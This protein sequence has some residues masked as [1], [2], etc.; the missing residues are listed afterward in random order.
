MGAKRKRSGGVHQRLAADESNASLPQSSRLGN[1]LLDEW[2]WGKASAQQVQHTAQLAVQDMKD[3]GCANPPAD[4]VFLASLGSGGTHANN[5]HRDLLKK[6]SQDS[7]M[8]QPTIT[9]LPLKGGSVPQSFF[10]PHEVF[11]CLYHEHP[12]SFQKLLVPG[13]PDQL[14][15]FW[16]RFAL[17][18]AMKESPVLAQPDFQKK[19]I[20]LNFHGDAVPCSGKGKVWCKMLLVLSWC[21]CLASGS[22]QDV[23][24]L[25]YAVLG[26]ELITSGELFESYFLQSYLKVVSI[27][28]FLCS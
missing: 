28:L 1:F 10:L 7:S 24:N 14:A 16:S 6:T 21:S 11:S 4:L 13:G 2:S 12:Q 19:T 23:C 9:N 27:E 18:P 5:M 22:T 25:C 20:P 17:H 26:Q 8:C 15:L 3:F